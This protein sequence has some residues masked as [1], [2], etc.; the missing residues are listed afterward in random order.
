[1]R[2]LFQSAVGCVAKALGVALALAGCAQFPATSPLERWEAAARTPSPERSQEMILILAFSGG[3]TRAAAFA[4]GVLEELAATQVDLGAGPRRLL[5][6]VDLISGVSGGSFTAAYY[7]LYGDRIFDD[8]RE[9]F[10]TRNVTRELVLRVLKPRNLWRLAS[11]HFNRSEIA[12]ELYDDTIF[13][14]STF[15]DFAT[16]TGPAIVLNATD[17]VRGN[18]FA[19]TQHQLDYLCSDLS[20]LRVARAV[21]ASSAVPGLLTPVQLRNH[22]GTCGFEA[23]AWIEEALASRSTS[24]R[25]RMQ[26]QVAESYLNADRRRYVHLVDGAIS[27]NLGILGVLEWVVEHGSLDRT[28]EAT[29]YSGARKILLI[30]VNA[31]TQR[32]LRLDRDSFTPGLA[33]ILG[34]TSGIQIRRSNFETL[35]LLRGSFEQWAAEASTKERPLSFRMVEVGF[36]G[37]ADDEER[38]HLNELPTSFSLDAEDVDLLRDVGRRLLRDSRDFQEA[39]GRLETWSQ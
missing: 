14:G 1:M 6:E 4:Y 22:A 15:A 30:A 8:F 3:G 34:L 19:F 39:L 2:R 7:G 29:G 38:R 25:R 5:D 32:E 21:A 10:L 35:Q 20:Q 12:A 24:P 31:Q 11:I 27:D 23:P 37:I 28:L 13:D 17:L 33:F 18:R 26:A 36:E 16:R 9:R